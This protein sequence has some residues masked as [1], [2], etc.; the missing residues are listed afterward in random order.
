MFRR[1]ITWFVSKRNIVTDSIKITQE[2]YVIDISQDGESW[3]Q[4][5]GTNDKLKL[6]EVLET[7]K[8]TTNYIK[9]RL[10]VNAE[11][12]VKK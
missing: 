9:V 8:P 2:A 10:S 7:L 1:F 11:I 5:A 6:D 4:I 12:T 3:T